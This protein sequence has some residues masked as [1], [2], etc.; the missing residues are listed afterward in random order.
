MWHGC[1]NCVQISWLK[2]GQRQKLMLMLP[3]MPTT[4]FIK[5]G[6]IHPFHSLVC[7]HA[8]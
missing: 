6:I 2:F 3:V 8:R 7:R 4:I 5:N 1:E